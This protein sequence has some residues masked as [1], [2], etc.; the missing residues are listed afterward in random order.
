M[1]DE[2]RLLALVHAG[3]FDA[4]ATHALDQY[5]PELFGFLMNTLGSESDASE[6][7]LQVGED[8]WRGLPKFAAR[9]SVRTWLY[10]LAR[11]AATDYRRSPWNR[12]ENRASAGRL[13]DILARMEAQQDKKAAMLRGLAMAGRFLDARR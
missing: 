8:L 5:G 12:R 7:F 10:V 9:S 6:V 13:D 3:D 2:G 4:A 11:N 1:G